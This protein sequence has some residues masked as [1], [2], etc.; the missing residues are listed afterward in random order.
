MAVRFNNFPQRE[1]LFD[2]RPEG[3]LRRNLSQNCEVTRLPGRDTGDNLPTA[4]C[5]NSRH[6]RTQRR[7]DLQDGTTPL[8]GASALGERRL[9][10]AIRHNGVPRAFGGEVGCRVID[11]PIGDR[12]PGLF[13]NPDGSVEI[14]IQ[15]E[16]PVGDLAA[17][18]LPAPEGRM[19]LALRA[20]LPREQLRDRSW[21]VPPMRR[22]DSDGRA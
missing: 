3:A 14:L 11:G 22:I 6:H 2:R 20:Y 16:R 9:A 10:Y 18:W 12:T 15:R 13:V 19:R 21:R 8:R 17:N 1:D 5:E 4:G 7:R